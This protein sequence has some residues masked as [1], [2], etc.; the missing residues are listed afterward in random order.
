MLTK[1]TLTI[2]QK[3]MEEAEEYAKSQGRILS[4]LVEEY[5]KTLSS[6]NIEQ[7]NLELSPITKSLFGAVKFKNK[8]LDYKNTLANKILKKHLK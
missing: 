2:D 6:K 1:I 8:N 5:L 3:V 4:K 7:K